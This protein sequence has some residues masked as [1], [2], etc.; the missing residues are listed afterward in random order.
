MPTVTSALAKVGHWSDHQ[1]ETGCTVIA[2]PEGQ[3]AFA[4]DV[5]ATLA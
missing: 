3:G 2:L 4:V 5:V 1:A